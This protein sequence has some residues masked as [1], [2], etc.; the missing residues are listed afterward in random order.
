MHDSIPNLHGLSGH[1]SQTGKKDE[2]KKPAG[3][4]EPVTVPKRVKI[5]EKVQF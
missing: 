1:R 5:S 4:D 2:K 3:K